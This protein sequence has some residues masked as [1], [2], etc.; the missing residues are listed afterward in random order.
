M[1]V[2]LEGDE[3]NTFLYNR[4]NGEGSAEKVILELQKRLADES[5]AVSPMSAGN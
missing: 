4:D 1:K 5:R 2:N 3:L